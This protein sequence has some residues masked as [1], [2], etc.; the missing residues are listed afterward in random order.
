LKSLD[1][2][3]LVRFL[4]GDDEAQAQLVHRIFLNAEQQG[5]LLYISTVV[6]LETIWVLDSVY[7]CSRSAILEAMEN[8]VKMPILCFERRDAVISLCKNTRDIDPADLLIGLIAKDAGCDTT[9]TFDRKA[10]K[11]GLFTLIE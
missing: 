1:T 9:L 3:V 7:G 8:L 2:N 11:S 10:A 4:I 6:L 5:Q